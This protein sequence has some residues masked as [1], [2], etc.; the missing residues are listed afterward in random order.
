MQYVLAVLALAATAIANPMEKLVVRQAVTASIAP[1]A[2]PPPGCTGSAV[3]SYG[4]VVHNMS[5]TAA[6]V[7]RQVTQIAE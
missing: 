1:A 2:P 7:K 5:T 4:I 6:P 3:G